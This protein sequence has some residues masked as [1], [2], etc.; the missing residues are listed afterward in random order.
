MLYGTA[1]FLAAQGTKILHRE[2]RKKEA[3]DSLRRNRWL[4]HR[5]WGPALI[6]LFFFV[7]FYILLVAGGAIECLSMTV[8]ED[9][10]AL[11]PADVGFLLCNE[12]DKYEILLLLGVSA[13]LVFAVLQTICMAVS[14]FGLVPS[15]AL[16]VVLPLI[17]SILCFVPI[18]N[19]GRRQTQGTG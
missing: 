18:L 14:Y 6:L 9:L 12:T 13:G 5:F 15:E 1:S 2:T 3:I 7:L 17:W 4:L 8:R 11:I 10:I 19:R 16:S